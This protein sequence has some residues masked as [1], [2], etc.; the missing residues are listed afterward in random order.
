M[1]DRL[2]RLEQQLRDWGRFCYRQEMRQAGDYGNSPA[3]RIIEGGK[4]GMMS[5]GTA[6]LDNRSD[7][8]HEP[9]WFTEINEPIQTLKPKHIRVLRTRYVVDPDV[10]EL[11]RFRPEMMIWK[12]RIASQTTMTPHVFSSLLREA[13]MML[14]GNV[15]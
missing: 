10:R 4:L 15:G 8:M 6:Y 3:N 9:D 13:Q 12:S 1:N 7:S 11:R 2:K 14:L 5:F